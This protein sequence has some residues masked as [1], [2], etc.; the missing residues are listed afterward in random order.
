MYESYDSSTM[1]IHYEA[2]L[3]I[4]ECFFFF[5]TRE[6]HKNKGIP[7]SKSITQ[8]HRVKCTN[9]RNL[10]SIEKQRAKC[11]NNECSS[12]CE[13]KR[14]NIFLLL[15]NNNQKTYLTFFRQFW[16]HSKPWTAKSKCALSLANSHSPQQTTSI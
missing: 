11:T 10:C 12:L 15:S 2:V 16:H 6:V 8:K 13:R 14:I 5:L 9:K 1:N 4:H 7:R 3:S